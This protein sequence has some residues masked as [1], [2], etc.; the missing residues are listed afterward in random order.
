MYH[1][2]YIEQRSSENQPKGKV[3]LNEVGPV[4]TEAMKRVQI[5][6]QSANKVD[7]KQLA[8]IV[9]CITHLI[10]FLFHEQE[11]L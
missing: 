11:R 9:D 8:M 3:K 1:Y 4:L 10:T 5:F 2:N 6:I 7:T